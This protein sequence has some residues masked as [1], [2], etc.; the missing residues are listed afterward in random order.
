MH[1]RHRAERAINLKKEEHS[2]DHQGRACGQEI[3]CK[4]E[5]VPR[6]FWASESSCP[7][8][9]ENKSQGNRRDRQ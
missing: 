5:V 2:G 4:K 7:Q 8:H 3:L 6:I 9:A 1:L